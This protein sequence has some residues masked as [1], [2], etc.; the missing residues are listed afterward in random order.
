MHII[1]THCHLIDDAFKTDVD[2]VVLHAKEADVNKM[3][4]A[5]CNAEE[6]D[7]IL[8][9]CKKHPNVLYP[10]FGI[11]PE[12]MADDVD[13]QWEE[14]KNAFETSIKNGSGWSNAPVG[15]VGIDLH[16]DK[17]RLGDQ[18]H[19][20]ELEMCYAAEHKLALLLH[21]RDAMPEFLDFVRVFKEKYKGYFTQPKEVDHDSTHE[22]RWE[23]RGILHCYS[24]TTEEALQALKLGNWLFGVGGTLTYKKSLVPEVV[25]NIGLERIV[26]E[27]DAPYLAP[28]PYRGK[29]NEPAYTRLTAQWLANLFETDLETV[30]Q[31]TTNNALKML[32]MA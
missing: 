6:Y 1:D 13:V 20:L 16:W 12:N 29:R 15:E 27:T 7:Q 4:L 28:M 9:L 19:L 17:T 2:E 22:P 11:H 3:L 21:I 32:Q 25:K 26:L 5:C 10:S 30:A 23:L 8:E 18:L 14:L 24:G 31:I